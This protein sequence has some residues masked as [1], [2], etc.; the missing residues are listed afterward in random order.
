MEQQN[1]GLDPG[2]LFEIDRDSYEPAYVQLVNIIKQQIA[3]GIYRPGDQLPSESQFC[4]QY[5]VSPMTV[6]RVINILTDQRVVSTIQ[7]RGTFVQP[8][9]LGSATFHLKG[10]QNFLM[11]KKTT[12][13]ILE[14][15]IVTADK[16][17]AEKL[18]IG[19]DERLIYIRRLLS[20]EKEPFLYHKEYLIYDPTRPVVESE[21]EV[22]SLRGLFNGAGSTGF[23]KGEL[24]I[25][26]TVINKEEAPVLQAE[27]GS[28][29][30]RLE[31][32][33]Y[34]FEEKP[35]SWGWFICRGDKL[36]F[37]STVGIEDK[38]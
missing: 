19:L 18:A 27:A 28:P 2:P 16:R 6:R 38:F 17:M 8:I 20:K 36:R 12:V 31:H 37:T 15:R 30:F 33:F 21:L 23:K 26:A 10:L 14:A 32:I 9:Q 24:S 35:A 13:T 34:D 5:Q 25:E 3:S 4:R 7:G 22:T 11:D 1:E 29:A